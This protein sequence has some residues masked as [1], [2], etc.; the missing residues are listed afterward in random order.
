M[1]N[2]ANGVSFFNLDL[3]FMEIMFGKALALG[4]KSLS[5]GLKLLSTDFGPLYIFNQ[6]GLLFFIFLTLF[7]LRIAM[8]SHL[9]ADKYIIFIVFL[10]GIHYQALFFLSSS[11]LFSL[12]AIHV[13]TTRKNYNRV[14]PH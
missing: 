11:F 5:T 8:Y 9:K 13:I 12:Y 14:L 2:T 7:L 6:M 3:S 10:S 1:V 4:D